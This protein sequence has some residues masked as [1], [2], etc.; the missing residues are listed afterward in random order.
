MVGKKTIIFNGKKI[1]DDI[2][3]KLKVEVSL[4]KKEGVTPKLVSVLIGKDKIS[5][6]YLKLKSRYAQ[7]IGAVLELRKYSETETSKKIK[8][9]IEI[10]N[11]DNLVHGIMVQLPFPNSYTPLDKKKVISAID[12][13]KD[14]DGMKDKSS[15]VAPAVR[16][17]LTALKESGKSKKNVVLLGSKGFVGKKLM[18]ALK[19]KGLDITGC[20]IDTRELENITLNADVL[21]SS[22]G[23]RGLVNGKMV[24]KGSGVIDVGQGDVLFKDVKKKVSFIT[25]VPGGIG[26]V[27][28][29]YLFENLIHSAKIG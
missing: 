18:K 19:E 5:E 17:V 25:P 8:D 23:R 4:L 9:D 11:K 29:A 13:R 7:K 6:K 22:T 27:T 2:Q 21:I 24:K 14:V 12:P 28:I 3:G 1:A 10:L 16:S 26:P 20:D 15:F